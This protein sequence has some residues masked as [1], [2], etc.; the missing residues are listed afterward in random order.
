MIEVNGIQLQIESEPRLLF[1]AN[2]TE[3]KGRATKT[4]S[5]IIAN[6]PLNNEALDNLFSKRHFRQVR[7]TA[8]MQVEDFTMIGSLLIDEL[9]ET[10]AKGIFVTSNALLWETMEDKNIR[11]YNKDLS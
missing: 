5:I 8:T 2:S 9:N 4:F 6:T 1:M 7:F 3:Y 11:S 10:S